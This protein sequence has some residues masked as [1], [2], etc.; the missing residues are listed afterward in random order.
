[1]VHDNGNAFPLNHD[2][3]GDPPIL[4]ERV[5]SWCALAGCDFASG[6][7]LCALDVVGAED[8]FLGS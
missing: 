3:H 4:F 6:V 2:L 8:V 1:L 5:D 7:E